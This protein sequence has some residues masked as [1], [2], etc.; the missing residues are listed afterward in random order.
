[1]FTGFYNI[2]SFTKRDSGFSASISFNIEHY[3]FKAHFPGNPITPGV[4]LLQIIQELTESYSGLKL[5]LKKVVNVKYLKLIKPQSEYLFNCEYIKSDGLVNVNCTILYRSDI[6]TKV[7]V[8][9]AFVQDKFEELGLTLLVPVYNN[10]AKIEG[11]I[12]SLIERTHR[13][14]VV[15]DGSTDGTLEILNKLVM[16]V[17]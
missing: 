2:S 4:C 10:A 11:V 7:S 1:M 3:I 17:F 14:I 6:Y 13:I 12:K 5:N 9:Y 16:S 15:N 8:K